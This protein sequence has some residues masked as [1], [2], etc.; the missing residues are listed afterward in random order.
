MTTKAEQ[1]AA[2]EQAVIDEA[3][4]AG[5]VIAT[6]GDRMIVIRHKGIDIPGSCT[7]RALEEIY[8]DKGWTED[9]GTTPEELTEV[10][11]QIRDKAKS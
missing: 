4:A 9:K 10:I 2:K 8:A 7:A 6:P 3:A 5:Q 11:A 1:E